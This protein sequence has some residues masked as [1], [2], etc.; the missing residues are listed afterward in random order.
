MAPKRKGRAAS[1]KAP[2]KPATAYTIIAP[3]PSFETGGT[4]SFYD[5]A[6]R[7]IEGKARITDAQA[8]TIS[9]KD[10]ATNEVVPFENAEAL[11]RHFMDS[12]SGTPGR[13]WR[14]VPDLPDLAAEAERVTAHFDRT[15]QGDDIRVEA[16]PDAPEWARISRAAPDEYNPNL[17][18]ARR[19]RQRRQKS[20][21]LVANTSQQ[22]RSRDSAREKVEAA[23]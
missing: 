15:P 12:M 18:R 17:G 6:I 4:K 20:A 9:Y 19:D 11:V 8:R 1:R 7:F 3:N 23:S 10:G 2:A 5:G 16:K 14:C 22:Q 21:P 13:E